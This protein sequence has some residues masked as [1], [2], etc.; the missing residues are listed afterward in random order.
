MEERPDPDRRL[1]MA[2]VTLLSFTEWTKAQ[3]RIA[4]LAKA[5]GVDVRTVVRHVIWVGLDE[6][7]KRHARERDDRGDLAA[8]DR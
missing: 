7:E 4:R 1:E 3:A 5:R 6:W 8:P 2:F